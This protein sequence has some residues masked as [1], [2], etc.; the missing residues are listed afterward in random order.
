MNGCHLLHLPKISDVRGNLTSIESLDHIPF[1]I[2]RVYYLY[3]V[4]SGETRGGHAHKNLEQ[5]I[6][7]ISGSF[8]INVDDGIEKR[9]FNL[10]RPYYG[11]YL[12]SYIWRTIE[13]FS[14]GATCLVL[15]SQPYKEEDYYRDYNDFLSAVQ[16][17]NHLKI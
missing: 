4:P 7:S 14:A 17:K 2:R 15:A 9:T 12:S 1:E 13:N 16:N 10:C 5:L 11:L 6:V 3:D 8:D